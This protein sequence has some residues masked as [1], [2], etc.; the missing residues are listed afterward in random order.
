MYIKDACQNCV[1]MDAMVRNQL[2][3]QKGTYYCFNYSVWWKCKLSVECPFY[4]GFFVD[5]LVVLFQVFLL[6]CAN[7]LSCLAFASR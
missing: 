3:D 6:S 4:K 2:G 1:V 5:E 7:K